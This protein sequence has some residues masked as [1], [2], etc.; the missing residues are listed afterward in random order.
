[1]GN[2]GTLQPTLDDNQGSPYSISYSLGTP[3]AENLNFEKLGLGFSAEED[4]EGIY[5]E[6]DIPKE[7]SHYRVSIEGLG[8]V[9]ESVY[10]L[11][12]NKTKGCFFYPFVDAGKVYTIRIVFLR[13]EDEDK[14]GFSL[15]HVGD[16]GTI[17][18]FQ[19]NAKAGLK[20][21]GEVRLTSKGEIF[22]DKKGNFKF[23]KRPTFQN[24][25]LLGNDWAVNMGLV[26]G[27]SWE[28][29]A[30]R[31][32]KWNSAEIPQAAITTLYNLYDAEYTIGWGNPIVIDFICVR[33]VKHYKHNDGKT[34]NYQWES[35]TKDI[36]YP[37]KIITFEDIDTSNPSQIGRIYGTWKW[38]DAWGDNGSHKYTETLVISAQKIERE[39][40]NIN[41]TTVMAQGK[42]SWDSLSAYLEKE[43]FE[44]DESYIPNR[45]LKLFED[46]DLGRLQVITSFTDSE[47]EPHTWTDVYNR[48]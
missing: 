48:Q 7:I 22:V 11:D 3:P 41:G 39:Y 40:S 14:D 43:Y 10:E 23:T 21:K 6:F 19:T 13:K 27:V 17:G 20:S 37:Q 46:S 36:F 12:E 35:F 28:H 42:E 47:G 32:T 15:G 33:P 26:E 16:D 4:S 29:G 1:M 45:Q 34:Y 2:G 18:W 9:A 24:E 5:L 44:N 30:E 31:K 38:S 8:A 25:H